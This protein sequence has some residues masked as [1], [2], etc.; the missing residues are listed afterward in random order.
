MQ[1]SCRPSAQEAIRL[2]AVAALVA[3]RAC[4]EVADVFQVSLK[5][6]DNWWAKW[7]AGGRESL[8][9]QPRGRR[10]GEHQGWRPAG[11]CSRSTDR[12]SQVTPGTSTG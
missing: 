11:W 4:E 12:N 8:V 9:A 6:V 7:L 3:G 5:A 2:R 10:P 1:G